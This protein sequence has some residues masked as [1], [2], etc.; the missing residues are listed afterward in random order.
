MLTA[1]IDI[2]GTLTDGLFTYDRKTVCVKV[3]TTPHDLT[4]CLFD[5]LSQGGA[6]LGFADLDAVVS[7]QIR[8]GLTINYFFAG[9]VPPRLIL[10][11]VA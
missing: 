11:W 10:L 6:Q 7:T 8:R 3:D 9:R 5:C 2:G 1:D 4:V